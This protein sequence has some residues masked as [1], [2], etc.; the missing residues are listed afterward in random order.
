[1]LW[2]ARG[3]LGRENPGRQRQRFLDIGVR[4]Q[5][6]AGTKLEERSLVWKEG[7]TNEET[8]KR[9]GWDLAPMIESG[10]AGACLS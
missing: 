1:M 6:K 7:S 4:G 9:N 3:K 10:R 2:R 5:R 8:N